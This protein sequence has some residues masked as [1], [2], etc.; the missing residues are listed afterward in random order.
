MSDAGQRGNRVRVE[1]RLCDTETMGL[2]PE[3][4]EGRLGMSTLGTDLGGE[5]EVCGETREKRTGEG[6][7]G[8]EACRAVSLTHPSGLAFPAGRRAG[9]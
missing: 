6:P 8:T 5:E 4:G 7:V 9:E 3:E 2:Q 1:P